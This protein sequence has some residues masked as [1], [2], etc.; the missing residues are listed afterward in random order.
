M[1]KKQKKAVINMDDIDY[2]KLNITTMTI[3][4]KLQGTINI[5]STFHLLPITRVDIKPKPNTMKFKL[6][7]AKQGNILSMRYRNMTRGIVKSTSNKYFKNS[8]TL[9]VSTSNK[10]ISMKISPNT[11]QMC[12][13]S[14]RQNGTEAAMDIINKLYHINDNLGYIKTH[15]N[16]Y[17]QAIAWL[18]ENCRGTMTVK[19]V[20]AERH[21]K[22]I[23]LC[24]P[25]NLD[26]FTIISTIE[27]P[28]ML[29][30]YIMDF[31]ISLQADMTYYYDYINKLEH[32]HMFQDA[33]TSDL[34]LSEINEVMVNY[35]FNLGFEVN[36][37]ALNRLIDGRNGLYSHYDNALVT[38]VTIELPHEH[39][40]EYKAKKH[41]KGIPHHTFLVYRSGSVTQSGPCSL[42]QPGKCSSMM[43]N[44]FLIFKKSI[45]EI[46]QDIII[47]G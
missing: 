39:P 16:N 29:D 21:F 31:L 18:K 19:T 46:K 7:V 17:H 47:H 25:K 6:P 2:K 27:C 9:D 8:I 13:A 42:H 45:N 35:N 44:A 22:N 41:K 37:D 14:S 20:I 40:L 34:I 23:T 1:M 11:L 24:Y 36:R 10:N 30:H 12:G 4:M 33:C 43:E 38:C 3:V 5:N 32:L 28:I 26:D 15:T